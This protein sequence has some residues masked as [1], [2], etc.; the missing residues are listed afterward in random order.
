MTTNLF[1]KFMQLFEEITLTG[2]LSGWIKTNRA[3]PWSP[4]PE[5][6]FEKS[7]KVGIANSPPIRRTEKA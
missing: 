6:I 5:L 7:L 3:R 4:W 1:L 2:I